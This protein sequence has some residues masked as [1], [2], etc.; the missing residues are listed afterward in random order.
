MLKA[1]DKVI[2]KQVNGNEEK[3]EVLF[4]KAAGMPGFTVVTFSPQNHDGFCVPTRMLLK[5]VE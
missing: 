4:P 1:G 3:C 5:D 2:Y